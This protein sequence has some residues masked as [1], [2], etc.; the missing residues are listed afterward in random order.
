MKTHFLVHK[1][2]A[3]KEIVTQPNL[4]ASATTT[5]NI[6]EVSVT[7]MRHKEYIALSKIE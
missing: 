3:R 1:S 4:F 2:G 6:Y 5:Q 7:S